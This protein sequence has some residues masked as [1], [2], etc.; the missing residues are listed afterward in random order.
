MAAGVNGP[1]NVRFKITV[2][3]SDNTTDV[4]YADIPSIK[5]NDGELITPNSKWESGYHYVYNL[6]LT[7]TKINVSA[8]LSDWT[9]VS[10]S[11]NV[12]M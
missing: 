6:K 4:Y 3:N 9:T 2:R 8:T 12:W 10:S 1:I 5:K 7:K 11:E